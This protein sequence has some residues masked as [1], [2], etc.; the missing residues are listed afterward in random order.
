MD[1]VPQYLS[2]KREIA[3][4]IRTKQLLP[5]DLLPGRWALTEKFGCSWATL[6]RAIQE[7]ILE[8]KL[9]AE[10][11]KGT[12]VSSSP[13]EDNIQL[14]TISV[15]LCNVKGSVY[16]SVQA[17]MEG[18]RLAAGTEGYS[19]QFIDLNDSRRFER[20]D[21][22]IVITPALSDYPFLA[23][24]LERGDRFVV[25]GSE[26]AFPEAKWV[27]S[28][29]REGTHKAIS[30]LLE[31]G[32]RQILLFG[33]QRDLSNYYL[34][35]RGYADA[36]AEYGLSAQP[37]W[38]V[39]RPERQKDIV[40][41]FGSWMKKNPE[42]TAVFAADYMSALSVLGWALENGVNI[43]EDLSLFVMG[44]VPSSAH[45]RVPLSSVV[46]PFKDMGKRAV[47]MLLEDHVSSFVSLPCKLIYRD[48][49]LP[50]GR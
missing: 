25:L 42:C 2:I 18:I 50:I 30:H 8:G 29:T 19:V 45:L 23:E 32:H 12:F 44:E 7:L 37:D 40:N 9:Y 11:G 16:Y 22:W 14:R 1:N 48:S 27:N 10:K 35:V 20:L 49:V 43:P 41:V 15:L 17:M 46:Q 21:E 26:F 3:R 28:D 47:H 4:Q 39:Y 36:L 5:N 24:A 33:L 34:K 31:H 13:V 6:N 38:M